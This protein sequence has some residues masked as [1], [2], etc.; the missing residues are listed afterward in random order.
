MFSISFQDVFLL[1][2]SLQTLL[3][4]PFLLIEWRFTWKK[5]FRE[6]EEKIK[7]QNKIGK[8][9]VNQKDVSIFANTPK[10]IRIT[11]LN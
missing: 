2:S 5:E 4:P 8:R 10:K 9:K 3:F 1:L 6:L 11:S 7:S